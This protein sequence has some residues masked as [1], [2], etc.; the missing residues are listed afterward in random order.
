MKTRRCELVALL[1]GYKLTLDRQ[2]RCSRIKHRH[3]VSTRGGGGSRK[4]RGSPLRPVPACLIALTAS[5][6]QGARAAVAAAFVS[7]AGYGASARL[8]E[9]A[10]FVSMAGRGASV[11]IAGAAA[12][13]SMEGGGADARIAGAAAFSRQA[14]HQDQRWP[15]AK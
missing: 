5:V 1:Q 12:F 2:L 4:R 9:A 14:S 7:M 6:G 13:V 15:A 8:V 10:A 3:P 11:R